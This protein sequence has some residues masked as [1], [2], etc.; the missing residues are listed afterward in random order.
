MG[1]IFDI[2]KL[3]EKSEEVRKDEDISGIIEEMRDILIE[4]GAVGIAS[5]QIGIKKNIVLIV[6]K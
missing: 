1:L 5:P 3:R 2:N 6:R 4:K